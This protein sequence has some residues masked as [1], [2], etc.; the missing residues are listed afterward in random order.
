MNKQHLFKTMAVAMGL[1]VSSTL[2]GQATV[3]GNN[4]GP[5][6]Y[7]GWDSNTGLPLRV[8][9]NGNHMIQWYTDSLYRMRLTETLTGQTMNGYPG[10]NLSG[11]LGVGRFSA[12]VTTPLA[13]LHLDSA[14]SQITGYRPWMG[15]GTLMTKRSDMMYVGMLGLSADR[16][17]AIIGWSDNAGAN[18]AQGPD[19]LRFIFTQRAVQPPLHPGQSYYGLEIA[20]MIPDLSGDEGFLGVGDWRA[21]GMEPVER[22]DILDGRVRIRKLPE[23]EGEA[24]DSY[25]VMVVDD[26]AA[27]NG[28]RGV[29]KWVDAGS[30][31]TGA[32][33]D[34][35]V[36]DVNGFSP[37][38]STA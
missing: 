8:M 1:L 30:L 36:Q 18:P 24:M 6:D 11:H 35:V 14:G 29:V 28:E 26:S 13:M 10:L 19:R 37:H 22:L 33:C 7:L 23:A 5:L 21:A 3:A 15:T 4:G 2:F 38:I 20:R 17:D 27:P 9:N 31:T 32:D 12:P 25:K 34:R 16:N